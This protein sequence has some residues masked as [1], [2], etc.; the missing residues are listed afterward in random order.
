MS[1]TTT[2]TKPNVPTQR[3]GG[4]NPVLHEERPLHPAVQTIYDKATLNALPPQFPLIV[5]KPEWSG[6]IPAFL[7]NGVF[8]IAA[9]VASS[10]YWTLTLGI[11][12]LL[13]G[14]M[15]VNAHWV[16]V[17]VAVITVAVALHLAG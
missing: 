7:T 2:T 16:R 6:D 10:I 1:A 3:M 12:L 5:A 8:F 17:A 11:W 15:W 4:G 9:G 13:H 14:L